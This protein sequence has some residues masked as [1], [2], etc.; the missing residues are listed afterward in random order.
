MDATQ[1]LTY[2]LARQ[3]PLADGQ[4]TAVVAG[5]AMAAASGTGAGGG[6]DGGGACHGRRRHCRALRRRQ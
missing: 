1:T 5:T 3:R 2:A 4:H 6:G